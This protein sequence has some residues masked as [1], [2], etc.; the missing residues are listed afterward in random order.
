MSYDWW[1]IDGNGWWVMTC[2]WWVMGDEWLI[3]V[4]GWRM[5]SYYWWMIDGNGDEW[6]VEIDE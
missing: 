1:V 5:I 2:Y 4:N 3:T 6:W